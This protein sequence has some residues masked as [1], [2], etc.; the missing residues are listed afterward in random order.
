M[1][2]A[3]VG[4]RYQK[5]DGFGLRSIWQV[6]RVEADLNGIRHCNIVDVT[7]WTN[8]KLIAEATLTKRRFYRLVATPV[9]ALETVE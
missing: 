2:E 4:Q 5:I 1:A 9:E 8:V 6:V 7:D 3:R